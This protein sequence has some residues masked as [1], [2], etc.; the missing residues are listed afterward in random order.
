MRNVG[1]DIA[2]MNP[3][4]SDNKLVTYHSWFACPLLDLQADSHTRVRNGG[5]P[6]MPPRYLHLG[7]PKHVM[8]NV[9]RFCLRAHTLVVESS[10]WRGGNGHCDKCSTGSSCAAVENEVHVLFHCQG[11]LVC[12]LR[13]K[14]PFLFFP[15]CLSFSMEAP[16]IPHALPS[17]TVLVFFLNGT[18][19]SAISFRTSWT[20]FW[21]AK[22]SNKPI[23]LTTWLAVNP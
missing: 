19:D 8:R 10:I 22:T 3:L 4:G 14:Y 6:L 7:L 1:R 17:Q 12:S 21:L 15:F 5:A 9:S 16:Y 18:T 2:D 20:T 11:L 13:I 23:S